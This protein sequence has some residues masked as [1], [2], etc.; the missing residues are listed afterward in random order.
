MMSFQDRRS[1][2]EVYEPIGSPASRNGIDVLSQDN[3]LNTEEPTSCLLSSSDVE[4]AIAIVGVSRCHVQTILKLFSEAA[5]KTFSL[6]RDIPDP[7]HQEF[8]V[9]RQCARLMK[10][11]VEEA[12]AKITSGIP[13]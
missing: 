12:L 2:T 6:S 8:D 3:S 1:I 10:P 13:P 5:G 7:W 4:S 11:L 9:Y